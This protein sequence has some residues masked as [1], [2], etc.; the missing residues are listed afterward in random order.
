MFICTFSSIL[1]LYLVFRND[2]KTK[3]NFKAL[4]HIDYYTY[5]KSQKSIIISLLILVTVIILIIFKDYI[6][7]NTGIRFDN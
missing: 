2:L 3:P 5:L 7:E 1:Y 4:D 6:L